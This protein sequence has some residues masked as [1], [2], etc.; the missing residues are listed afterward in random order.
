MRFL[1]LFLAFATFAARADIVDCH[2][3]VTRPETLTAR[4][5]SLCVE[6]E[7]QPPDVRVFILKDVNPTKPGRWIVLPRAHD[8]EFAQLPPDLR[9]E[10]LR[11]AIEK[12][13]SL[14]GDAWGVAY[15]APALQTQCH[16]HL[17]IGKWMPAVENSQ[18]I[19]VE[20][21]EDIPAPPKGVG[22]WIHP[23]GKT[24]HVHIG[25]EIAETVLV[26]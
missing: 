21:I 3:D 4:Q 6:A 11:T 17:H 14:F 7:K 13:K 24:L 15:N 12:A 9:T 16:V 26:R 19:T 20:R 23:V 5:C 25:D 18:F 1:P 22:F 10:L 8:R 2:C